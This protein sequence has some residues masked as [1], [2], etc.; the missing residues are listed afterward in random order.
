MMRTRW[1]KIRNDLLTNKTRT[2]LIILSIAIGL[3]AVGTIVSARAV[4]STEIQRSYAA[5]V[6]SNGTIRTA[7]LF[8]NDF[9]NSV[10]RIDGVQE[11]DAR[12]LFTVRCQTRPGEWKT[13]NIYVVDDY[14]KIRLNKIFPTEGVF[15]PPEREIL[16]ERA[17]MQ[18][19]DIAIGDVIKIEMPNGKT[20]KLTV[21]GTV[22][23]MS[24]MPAQI[25]NTP[26]GYV[27]FETL[28]W[29]GQSYGFNE[30]NIAT[31]NPEDADFVQWV[32]SEVKN[33]AERSGM[34]PSLALVAEPGQLPLDDLLNA[35]LMVMGFLGFLS[36]MMSAILIINTV[37]A[38]LAQQRRQIGILK[39]I[40]ATT[41]QL[42][43]MYLAM[44]CCYGAAALIISIPVSIAASRAL[45]L[46]LAKMFNFDLLHFS[47]PFTSIL[48]QVITGLLVPVLASLTPFLN[49]LKV[50]AVQ[51][52][53]A[54]GN[55]KS[56]RSKSWI[57]RA[58]SGSKLWFARFIL[59]RPQ[60]LSIRNLFRSKQRLLFTLITLILGGGIFISVFSTQSSIER[61]LD[62]FV[63][64]YN[65]DVMVS[66]QR[67]YRTQEIEQAGMQIQEVK[68]IEF[69]KM[70][71]SRMVRSDKSETTTINMIVIRTNTPNAP[72]P[73]ITEGRW[74][75]PD[76]ENAVIISST[77][78]RDE[79]I[80]LGDWI[81]LKIDGDDQPF[82]VVGVS[83]GIAAPMAYTNFSYISRITDEVN[84]ADAVL[85]SLKNPAALHKE[86][87]NQ[88]EQH[89]KDKGFQV[90]SVITMQDET[91]EAYNLFGVI[92]S[93]LLIMA[94]LLALV[95][96]LG[97]MGTMG[98]NVLERTRE[99]GVMRA[100]GASNRNVSNVFI[101]EG[102]VIGLIS[103]LFG[104]LLAIPL[105]FLLNSGIG[106]ALIGAPLNYAYS[107]QGVWGW[108]ALVLALS[109]LA[110]FIPARNASKLTVREV[111]SYE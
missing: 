22:H 34:T 53:N 62:D 30:L 75:L 52:M 8:E 98:I 86:T 23:D 27:S 50:S 76:D 61:T 4:L 26:Y 49:M 102:M 106:L 83:L 80:H 84:Q 2:F 100:I 72:S 18:V 60:L 97:L 40:G 109:A 5:I 12:R 67:P 93:L 64:W 99:I 77:F 101:M 66:L 13:I 55:I 47:I 81:T 58:I 31:E 25:D 69:W 87:V 41:R 9:V 51:A 46:F 63:K 21:S 19:L 17:A 54:F 85:I 42:L 110:S 94:V 103:W 78:A 108:L 45:S 95:G 6:P 20:R 57:D 37:T 38:M 1:Y 90:Y 28:K 79:N 91:A 104:A 88:I 29:F 89:F 48:I 74:L 39:A 96:G 35:I 43:E 36:L 24:Q 14:Q 105:M 107:F 32:N 7:E 92:T 65:F 44:V 10:R 11:A 82:Q 15:P 68:H 73:T 56:V 3:M 33:H 71:P 111:L 59:F 70:L 16:I